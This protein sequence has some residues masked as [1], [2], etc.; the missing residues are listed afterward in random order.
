MHIQVHGVCVCGCVPCD[1]DMYVN[2]HPKHTARH[3]EI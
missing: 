3:R 1:Y 2:I